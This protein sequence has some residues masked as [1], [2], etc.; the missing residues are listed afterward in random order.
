VL[1]KKRFQGLASYGM[2]WG[3]TASSYQAVLHA[4]MRDFLD[5]AVPV[6]IEAAR[7]S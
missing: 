1:A 5:H 6:I 2:N 7:G 4:A 3:A